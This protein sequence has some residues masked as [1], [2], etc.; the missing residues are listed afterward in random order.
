MHVAVTADHRWGEH[1]ARAAGER[2]RPVDENGVTQPPYHFPDVNDGH[3][4]EDWGRLSEALG[5]NRLLGFKVGNGDVSPDDGGPFTDSKFDDHYQGCKDHEIFGIGY[6]WGPLQVESF[7]RAFPPLDGFVPA[8]D[9]EGHHVGARDIDL[10]EAFLTR[11]DEEWG[12]PCWFYGRR[13]WLDA[14]APAGTAAENRPWWGSRYNTFIETSIQGLGPLTVWQYKGGDLSDPRPDGW[15]V[16]FPG[17]TTKSID[18]NV[19]VPPFEEVFDVPHPADE[20]TDADVRMLRSLIEKLGPV[21]DILLGTAEGLR[22]FNQGEQLNPTWGVFKRA[23]FLSGRLT[24][25]ERPRRGEGFDP[26]LDDDGDTP[27]L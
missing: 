23:G 27:D 17:V 24:S 26:L 16:N 3:F 9:C 8:F 21:D 1:G 18:M 15:P 6:W 2:G 20:L 4:V 19:L 5:E 7:L 12:Q 10:I 11:V 22:A 25:A 13:K 14:G